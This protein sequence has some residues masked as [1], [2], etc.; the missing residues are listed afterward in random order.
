MKNN[1]KTFVCPH[2]GAK[3]KSTAK[4]CPHCGS[5]ANTGWSE[6]AE[7]S[8]LDL[9]DYEEILENETKR[10]KQNPLIVVAAIIIIAAFAATMIL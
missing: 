7:F 10:K 3:V 6:G 5:D 2:C 9:P 8:D 4:S 1:D